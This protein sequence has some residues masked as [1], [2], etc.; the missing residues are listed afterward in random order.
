MRGYNPFSPIDIKITSAIEGLI[1]LN[2]LLDNKKHVLLVATRNTIERCKLNKWLHA[3]IDGRKNLWFYNIPSNPGVAD[4]VS[5]LKDLTTYKIDTILSIGGGSCIDLAKAISA[6]KNN[7]NDS[8]LNTETIREVIKTKSYSTNPYFIDI[9]AIPTT[10][11]T[12]S[13]VTR[14]ATVWDPEMHAKLSI[15]HNALYP[16]AA[17]IIPEFTLSMPARLTLSTGLDALSHAMEAFWAKSRNL[18]SQALAL[19]AIGLIKEN[20]PLALSYP[21]D[22]K[23]REG[24]A[25]GSLIAGLA[26]SMTRTTA[27]HSISYPL[28]MR[29]GI[30]HGFAAAIS[31]DE[32]A[33]RNTVAVPEIASIYSIF[34]NEQGFSAWLNQI[35]ENIQPLK[36]SHFGVK[37]DSI[38]VLVNET[39]TQGRMDNNPILFTRD[40]VNEILSCIFNNNVKSL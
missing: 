5:T 3:F 30:E 14:W 40:D 23:F 15:E 19:E 4:V 11:G 27:C 34:D 17:I 33:R 18:L 36:L 6:L 20:L 38:E 12:G 28:T 13:E 35:C 10:S 24:M 32:V 1:Y 2:E 25:M 7:V 22:I 29:F 39:F 16:K 37:L 9:I 21:S 31:L 26:F 8:E